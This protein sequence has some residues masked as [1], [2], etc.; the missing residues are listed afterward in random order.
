[1]LAQ[2]GSML[3]HVQAMLAQAEA[4]LAKTEKAC[5]LKVPILAQGE[6][7]LNNILHTYL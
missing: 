6:I 2:A 1:M 4:I 3:A 5:W 7:I